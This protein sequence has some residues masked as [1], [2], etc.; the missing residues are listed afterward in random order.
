MSS[1]GCVTFLLHDPI[2]VRAQTFDMLQGQDFARPGADSQ[3][4]NM[5][6]LFSVL[7][8]NPENNADSLKRQFT[9]HGRHE[10]KRLAGRDA[11]KNMARPFSELGFQTADHAR[12]KTGIDQVAQ[13]AMLGVVRLVQL[14]AGSPAIENLGPAQL[15]RE[16]LGV[17][18]NVHHVI[19]ATHHPEPLTA[20]RVLGRRMPPDRGPRAA[21]GRKKFVREAVGKRT[22]VRQINRLHTSLSSVGWFICGRYPTH[23]Q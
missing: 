21:G 15:G 13:A 10:I 8:R 7:L 12:Q 22:T 11:V 16:G 4:N 5:P 19:V 14:I 20:R 17:L 18:K 9:R 2:R 3:V 6:Q 23:P 1:A